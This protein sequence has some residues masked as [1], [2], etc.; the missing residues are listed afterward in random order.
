MLLA[1]LTIIV[2]L[3]ETKSPKIQETAKEAKHE[4]FKDASFE[5]SGRWYGLC[6]KNSIISIEDF[7]RIVQ[8]DPV[9]SSHF[10][11][12][13]WRKA[14]TGKLSKSISAYVSFRKKGRIFRKET[15]IILPEGDRY[16][17]DG[18][19]FVRTYCC[20]DFVAAPTLPAS[21]E[22][23]SVP[24]L[25]GQEEAVSQLPSEIGTIP[26]LADTSN[27]PSPDMLSSAR[28]KRSDIDSN[29]SLQK[30]ITDELSNEIALDTQPIDNDSPYFPP[31]VFNVPLYNT[32]FYVPPA[33]FNDFPPASDTPSSSVPNDNPNRTSPNGAGSPI[34]EPGT[35]ILTGAGVLAGWWIARRIRRKVKLSEQSSELPCKVR[36]WRK[37]K[38]LS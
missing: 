38:F 11:S 31:I 7:R 34:P 36:L 30:T 29:T 16:I 22:L 6:S 21:A 26:Y 33:D 4:E 23:L 27:S 17:T 19:M 35:L 5:S 25:E 32:P 37:E 13:D 14:R 10:A 15:P 8:R 12:F 24:T 18:N 20:N 1:I 28:Q 9:L 2:L 3:Q